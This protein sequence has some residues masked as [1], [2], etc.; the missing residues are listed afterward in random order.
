MDGLERDTPARSPNPGALSSVPGQ[1]RGS[2]L[3][4]P[5]LLSC[6]RQAPWKLDSRAASVAHKRMARTSYVPLGR[7]RGAGSPP[8]PSAAFFRDVQGPVPNAK[9]KFTESPRSLWSVIWPQATK[10][11]GPLQ[12]RRASETWFC[13]VTSAEIQ[14]MICRLFG[15]RSQRCNVKVAPGNGEISLRWDILLLSLGAWSLP[16]PRRSRSAAR[17]RTVHERTGEGQGFSCL[18]HLPEDSR[19]SGSISNKK[20]TAACGIKRAGKSTRRETR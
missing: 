13:A 10:V 12:P 2:T 9:V 17:G 8:V 3:F 18:P 11:T 5:Q 15:V 1:R 19:V 4:H 16:G 20:G 6:R 14:S 7:G